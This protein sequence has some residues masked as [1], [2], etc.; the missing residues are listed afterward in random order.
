MAAFVL[1]AGL[2]LEQRQI[3]WR[4]LQGSGPPPTVWLTGLDFHQL[5]SLQKWAYRRRWGVGSGLPTSDAA[6]RAIKNLM[7]RR[8]PSTGE[9]LN[10]T[11]TINSQEHTSLDATQ[12]INQ[13]AQ[14]AYSPLRNYMVPGLTSQLIAEGP[15]GKVRVFLSDRDQVDH[16]TPH[17]H[18]FDFTCLVLKGGVV[19]T[20]YEQ[21]QYGE[22][23]DLFA[24]GLLTHRGGLPGAGVVIPGTQGMPYKRIERQYSEQQTYAMKAAQIHSIRFLK[25]SVVLFFEGPLLTETSVVLEPWSDGQRVP[26]YGMQPWM[27]QREDLSP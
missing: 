19:N 18:R 26:T 13:L 1:T 27:F 8:Q 20:L 12:I 4:W 9:I 16:I 7:N 22:P 6:L 25:G 14:M 10:D 15:K 3:I 23:A 17:S 21:S 2:P 5:D 11:V 24:L